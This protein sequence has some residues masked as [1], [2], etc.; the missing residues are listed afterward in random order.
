MINS[1]RLYRFTLILA[2]L[3]LVYFG[4]LVFGSDVTWET[5]K[6]TIHGQWD[7]LNYEV[8]GVVRGYYIIGD[9]DFIYSY[10]GASASDYW[11]F[12]FPIIYHIY[13]EKIHVWGRAYLDGVLVDYDYQFSSS[14]NPFGF[15]LDNYDEA[16][17]IQTKVKVEMA[18]TYNY[19]DV[20]FSDRWEEDI[21]WNYLTL[22]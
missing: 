8:T 11:Y 21:P 5:K 16:S 20:L 1:M 4:Y 6:Y 10:H 22:W 7:I 14:E 9:G 15:Y 2:S 19:W 13:P 3:L 12:Y 18:V 17:K